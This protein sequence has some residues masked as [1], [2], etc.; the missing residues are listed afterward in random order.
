MTTKRVLLTGAGTG[1]G[2]GAAIEL[3]A[4]GHHVIATTATA[5]Q[6]TALRAEAPQLTVEKVDIT[7]PSD[8]AKAGAWEIDVLVNNAGAGCLG[9]LADVP[10]EE[11]RHVFEVNVFGTLAISKAF[12]G[13]MIERGSGRILIVSS[14]AGI[15]PAG[16]ISGPYAMTKYALEAMG[17]AWRAELEPLGVEVGL[18]NPGPYGTGFNDAMANRA[19]DRLGADSPEA[20][21]AQ[22]NFLHDLITVDQ[23]DPSEV[24]QVMADLVEADTVPLQ[25]VVPAD[26]LERFGL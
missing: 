11:I 21:S 1:F 3:A 22:V 6:T 23:M 16:P 9:P 14:I 13:Q 8:V 5:D 26:L 2:K 7:D 19:V 24:V 12:V 4:R 15:I 25:T 18:I 17:G 10:L 20:I